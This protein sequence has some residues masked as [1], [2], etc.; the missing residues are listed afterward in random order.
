[1]QSFRWSLGRVYRSRF[2]FSF[3]PFT[4]S[5]GRISSRKENAYIIDFLDGFLTLYS[6]LRTNR[7][8]VDRARPCS[9]LGEYV[10]QVA[11]Y[12]SRSRAVSGSLSHSLLL[13]KT[14][15]VELGTGRPRPGHRPKSG[16]VKI[17]VIGEDTENTKSKTREAEG[18]GR[19]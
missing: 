1:M 15:A 11:I 6:E 9:S 2:F 8:S 19:G 16:G 7:H 4:R 10:R 18:T 14:S 12:L 17:Y 13:T 3:F 5:T